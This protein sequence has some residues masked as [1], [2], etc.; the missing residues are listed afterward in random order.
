MGRPPSLCG[1]APHRTDLR[2][3]RGGQASPA[4]QV[5]ATAPPVVCRPTD[6]PMCAAIANPYPLHTSQQRRSHFHH[7]SLH[8]RLCPTHARPAA[9][10][11]AAPPPPSPVSCRLE[12]PSRL[13]A[14]KNH[15][16]M[17]QHPRVEPLRHEEGPKPA[18]VVRFPRHS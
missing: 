1:P 12:P 10:L 11:C 8:H 15:R 5:V 16:Q 7:A 17:K 3:T 18:D 2:P 9:T 14:A 6:S 4:C 13:H